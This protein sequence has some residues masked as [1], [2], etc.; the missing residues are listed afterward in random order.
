MATIEESS[1]KGTVVT[2]VGAKSF[3]R[4]KPI[5]YQILSENLKKPTKFV[6]QRHSGKVLVNGALDREETADYLLELSAGLQ[7]G[8]GSMGSVSKTFV[9]VNVLDENDNAPIFAQPSFHLKVPCNA[10]VGKILYRVHATD[11][12]AGE[13][14]RIKFKFKSKISY[15]SILPNTGKIRL[16]KSLKRFCNS[17]RPQKRFGLT[18]VARDQGVVPNV[19]HALMQVEVLPPGVLSSVSVMQARYLD[20]VKPVT[21]DGDTVTRRKVRHPQPRHTSKGK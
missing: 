14:A 5:Y 10:S 11:R 4:S 15:F 8:N 19:A 3:I 12:D 17:S 9:I 2:T 13:N 7:H 6:I 20:P 1:K 18:I 16:L 21:H